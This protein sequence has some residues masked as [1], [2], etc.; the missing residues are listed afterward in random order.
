[1]HKAICQP[2]KAMDMAIQKDYMSSNYAAKVDLTWDYYMPSFEFINFLFSFLFYRSFDNFE[3][4]P[5]SA[6]VF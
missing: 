3:G 6:S 1:M 5:E 4:N 2:K